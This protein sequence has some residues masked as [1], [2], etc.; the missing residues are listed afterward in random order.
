MSLSAIPCHSVP[1]HGYGPGPRPKI[2]LSYSSSFSTGP[3]KFFNG[4]PFQYVFTL[5]V[6]WFP[7]TIAD[8]DRFADRLMECGA[9]LDAD[10]P[11]S[12]TQ[13]Y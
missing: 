8:L 3:Q 10:H 13:L 9:E 2:G 7:R 4:L 12:N 5:P 6:P 1:S 11:V